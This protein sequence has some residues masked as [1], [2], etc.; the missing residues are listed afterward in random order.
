M[1]DWGYYIYLIITGAILSTLGIFMLSLSTQY[2]QIFV[3]QGLCI[4]FGCGMLFVPTM[5]LIARSFT[6]N[7]S[8]AV[9][10]TT[11]GAPVGGVVYTI[12][13]QAMLPKLG[14]PWTVR[15]L[16]FYMLGTYCVAI[17][18]VLVGAKNGRSLTTGQRRKLFDKSALKDL[19][20][21][22]YSMVTFFTF[23]AYL[24]PYF[25]MPYYAQTVLGV[26]SS[27]ASYTLVAS[28][29]AS[30]PGRLLAAT[31][32]NY[33][34]VMAAWTGCATI[35]AIVCFAWIGVKSYTGFMIFCGFYG[36][37]K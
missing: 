26:S 17:P 19:P 18:L 24:V 25:Y 13:F 22:A 7:R 20:F 23:M 1:F 8:I 3:T 36:K 31:V 35:S 4:G 16:G 37:Y 28:Q 9:G 29:A 27:K 12:L 34:G 10:V 5:A 33:F 6:K 14:F 15:V 11:C 32:A 21:W 30:I 2:W